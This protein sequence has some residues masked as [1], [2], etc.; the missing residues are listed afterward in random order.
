MKVGILTYHR[1][2]NYG[3]VLQC[4]A[5]QELLKQYGCDIE[6][7]DYRQ[8][9]I[10]KLYSFNK[11]DWFKKNLLHPRNL[12]AYRKL[13]K[14]QQQSSS[15]FN[16][17]RDS[18][19][20]S[21]NKVIDTQIPTYD[22]Y[23]VG[24]DQMWSINCVGNA[25][26]NV[27]FGNFHRPKSSKLIGFSVSSNASS[28]NHIGDS[29]INYINNFDNISFRECEITR[30]VNQKFKKEFIT[31][32]DPTLC[33]DENRWDNIIDQ[34]WNKKKPY[35]VVYHVKLRF[36][37]IAHDLMMKQAHILASKNNW[38]IID[39]SSGNYSVTDFVS[40]IKYSQGVVTSSFHATV[41]AVIFSRPILSV[42][43]HDGNDGRYVDLLKSLNMTSSLVDLDF[44]PYFPN[45]CN[46]KNV[47]EKLYELKQPSINYLVD[48]LK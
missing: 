16:N 28:I 34:S 23:I 4:F 25:I 7:I 6:I 17:F 10:E 12:L 30:L 43:L 8:P 15:I 14:Q 32:L 38:D 37:K 11:L 24:S 13:L 5:L 44:D 20:N 48:Y 41:F 45:D 46:F 3:A 40:A 31:T 22:L 36:A 35:I 42:K 19:L 9:F 47:H 33:L 2:H 26:D 21:S 27:Y 1:A 39:L 29:L 18:F